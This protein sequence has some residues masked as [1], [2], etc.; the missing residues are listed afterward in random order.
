MVITIIHYVSIP[1]DE[2][3]EYP[4]VAGY[5]YGVQSFHILRQFMQVRSRIIHIPYLT[6]GIEVIE[7][8]RQ[9]A[10]MFRSYAFFRA[11]IKKVFKSFM[12]E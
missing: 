8:V 2:F 4:P 7:D 10:G 12:P 11:R 3:E 1:F 9:S 6:G 5:L